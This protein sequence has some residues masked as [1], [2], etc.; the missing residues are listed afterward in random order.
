M[1]WVALAY[2]G[3]SESYWAYF[4]FAVFDSDFGQDITDWQVI[5]QGTG[6]VSTIWLMANGM[7]RTTFNEVLAYTSFAHYVFIML[8]ANEAEGRLKESFEVAAA[9]TG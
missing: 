9:Y 7:A 1:D 8:A 2:Y 4:W 3:F 5:A 6:A